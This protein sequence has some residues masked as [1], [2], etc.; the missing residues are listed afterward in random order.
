MLFPPV[1]T[2]LASN[3][4]VPISWTNLTVTMLSLKQKMIWHD[5]SSIYMQLSLTQDFGQTA[6][7][8]IVAEAWIFKMLS[9]RELFKLIVTSP[10][11]VVLPSNGSGRYLV[12]S[13]WLVVLVVLCTYTA[14]LMAQLAVEERRLPFTTLEKAVEDPEVMF[15]THEWS[16][17]RSMLEVRTRRGKTS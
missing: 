14:N 9:C 11:G 1:F 10:G 7:Q 16:A 8:C 4:S 6:Q 2:S 15:Y 17:A 3:W 13:F 5:E 12:S